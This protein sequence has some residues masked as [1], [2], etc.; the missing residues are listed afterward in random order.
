MTSTQMGDKLCTSLDSPSFITSSLPHYKLYNPIFKLQLLNPKPTCNTSSKSR[1][2]RRKNGLLNLT[3][4]CAPISSAPSSPDFDIVSTSEG[5]DGSFVFRFG[6]ASEMERIRELEELRKLEELRELGGGSNEISYDLKVLDGNDEEEVVVKTIERE[7]LD[8][9]EEHSDFIPTSSENLIQE[10]DERSSQADILNASEETSTSALDSENAC[11]TENST[12]KNCHENSTST[13]SLSN[14]SLTIEG[15]IPEPNIGDESVSDSVNVGI[16][17]TEVA[18]SDEGDIRKNIRTEDAGIDNS[19]RAVGILEHDVDSG[20]AHEG[21]N[22]NDSLSDSGN[23]PES[24]TEVPQ[25]NDACK[26]DSQESLSSEA[27]GFEESPQ[28]ETIETPVMLNESSSISTLEPEIT[29][30]EVL[31]GDMARVSDSDAVEV[32]SGDLTDAGADMQLIRNHIISEEISTP[33]L[34]LSSGA[35]LLP[36]PSKA[37]AGG[38]ESYFVTNLNWLGVADGVGQWSLEGSNPGVYARELMEHCGKIVSNS[39]GISILKPVEVLHRIVAEAQ[40]PGSS[41]ILLAHFDG[42]ILHVANIGDSGFIVIRNGTVHRCSSPMHHEFHFPLQI[43]KGHDPSELVEEYQIDLELGD[44]VVTAT[45]G[46]L[47][48]LYM[49]EI[50]ST[51]A[52]SLDAKINAQEIAKLL[53]RRAQEVGKSAFGNSPF[54]DSARA[55]GYKGYTGGKLDDVAVIVSLV[56]KRLIS[57]A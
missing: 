47:D 27:A 31:I 6:D 50:A 37:L 24:F 21:N 26:D 46:L 20:N 4:L 15:N 39:S 10:S 44:I 51:V 41:T 40:S 53:A 38:E 56:Q 34:C 7:G 11:M 49:E 30:V 55:A 22:Y 5:S 43:A 23:L 8:V 33:E 9:S 1:T 14:N 28:A 16:T 57:N 32:S 2:T 18:Q 29:D 48:N 52:K 13:C 35:A 42:Q 25:S 36:H 45:D 12:Q 54:A 19:V 17:V 3:V